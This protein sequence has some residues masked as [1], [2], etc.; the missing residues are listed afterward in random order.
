M[1]YRY[2]SQSIANI[3]CT[4]LNCG[5]LYKYM[6]QYIHS[7]VEFDGWLHVP[8]GQEGE[9]VHGQTA[10]SR[11]AESG[12][13]HDFIYLS[14]RRLLELAA[15]SRFRSA[16][17]LLWSYSIQELLLVVNIKSSESGPLNLWYILKVQ[18]LPLSCYYLRS[19]YNVHTWSSKLMEDLS[20]GPLFLVSTLFTWT[21]HSG[22]FASC[23]LS[24]FSFR[25]FSFSSLMSGDLDRLFA[26][27]SSLS[28]TSGRSRSASPAS[29]SASVGGVWCWCWWWCWSRRY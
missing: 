11:V 22:R 2:L 28:V 21:V 5:P 16:L 27:A 15:G 13:N 19:K 7:V 12:L 23:S 3:L 9:W 1:S 18:Q 17:L 24:C 25:F 6:L 4:S 29:L 8:Q 26:Q 10:F 20:L 14:S